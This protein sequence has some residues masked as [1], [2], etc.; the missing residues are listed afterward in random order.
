MTEF[1]ARAEAEARKYAAGSAAIF[2]FSSAL[3]SAYSAGAQFGYDEARREILVDEKP[4]EMDPSDASLRYVVDEGGGS[5]IGAPPVQSVTISRDQNYWS[6]TFKDGWRG[7]MAAYTEL[8]NALSSAE[9][10]LRDIDRG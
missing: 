8:S 5:I 7:G 10:L 9:C 3:L 2:D 1:T 6:V 4:Y